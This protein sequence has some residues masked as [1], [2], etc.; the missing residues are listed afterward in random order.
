[1]PR[2]SS[3]RPAARHGRLLRLLHHQQI[4]ILRAWRAGGSIL[5]AADGRFNRTFLSLQ[6]TVNAI[7]TG[8]RETG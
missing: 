7:S 4:Q 1:V 5:E 6:L 8:L 2:Q 3:G